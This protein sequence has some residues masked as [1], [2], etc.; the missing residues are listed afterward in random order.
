M[1]HFLHNSERAM[2]AT[3]SATVRALTRQ[4]V[5]TRS[6]SAISSKHGVGD[7]TLRTWTRQRVAT[8]GGAKDHVPS[9]ASE[10]PYTVGPALLGDT[11]NLRKLMNGPELRQVYTKNAHEV[12]PMGYAYL[13]K[14]IEDK[15]CI[16]LVIRLQGTEIVGYVYAYIDDE[17]WYLAELLVLDK[18]RRQGLGPQLVHGVLEAAKNLKGT[19]LVSEVK[20][21]AENDGLVLF[22]ENLGFEKEEGSSTIMRFAL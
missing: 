1:R 7:K 19:Q 13:Q 14:V 6:A 3:R 8:R 2:V 9:P 17:C 16:L 21:E 18:H 15:D 20:L 5:A 12:P 22:Y 10:E 4:S 11:G